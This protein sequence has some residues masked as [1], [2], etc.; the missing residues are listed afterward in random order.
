[1]ASRL[2]FGEFELDVDAYAL[3]SGGKP[4]RLERQPMELLRLLLD[5]RGALVDRAKIQAALWDSGVFVGHEAAINTA[6]RKLRRALGDD[7]ERPRYIETV[8]GKGYRFAAAVHDVTRDAHIRHTLRGADDGHP[9]FPKYSVRRGQEEFALGE[10]D[11]L[12][13]RHPDARVYIDHPSVSRRHAL[14]SIRGGGAAIE[15]LG[16]R[17]GTFVDGHRVEA[18]TDLHPGAIVG[19]GPIVMTFE[20]LSAPASTKPVRRGHRAGP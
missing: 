1:M 19:A 16:S 14:I 11:N 2:R 7:P 13:G 9:L 5:A 12:I 17:N 6:I 10:G 8:V 4:V 20:V 18:R 15:D 3:R